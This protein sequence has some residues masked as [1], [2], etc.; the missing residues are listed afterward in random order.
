LAQHGLRDL[1]RQLLD[2]TKAHPCY[3]QGWP[4]VSVCA[5][6]LCAIAHGH[7]TD[8]ERSDAKT[9]DP[10]SAGQKQFDE[11]MARVNAMRDDQRW[12]KVKHLYEDDG[13]PKKA[14]IAR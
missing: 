11:A 1:A 12:D 9:P 4:I 10:R 6:H 5:E 3:S 14:F 7:E 13:K 8:Q 2:V